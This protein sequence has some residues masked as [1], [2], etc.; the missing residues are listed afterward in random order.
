VAVLAIV[1]VAAVSA[2]SLAVRPGPRPEATAPAAGCPAIPGPLHADL[3]GDGCEE[4][5]AFDQGVLTTGE[6]RF[7][8]GQPGDRVAVG[9]WQCGT[10][11][12]ALLRPATGEVFRFDGWPDAAHPARAS[13]VGR[14]PE[15]V[16]IEAE[17]HPHSTCDDLLA[18]RAAGPPVVIRPEP[19]T[20]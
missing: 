8:V 3:D 10:P 4:S 17:P 1:A 14:V 16:A 11:T 13:V 20:G 2:A 9:R 6:H 5:L 12:L 15:A 19:V 18:R 7:S